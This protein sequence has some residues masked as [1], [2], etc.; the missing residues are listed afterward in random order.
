MAIVADMVFQPRHSTKTK[1][2]RLFLC[3]DKARAN[4]LYTPMRQTLFRF[5]RLC[6]HHIG[7]NPQI[8]KD[9]ALFQ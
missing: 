1:R 5:L 4:D 7:P 8:G 6:P 2:R 9:F 3:H